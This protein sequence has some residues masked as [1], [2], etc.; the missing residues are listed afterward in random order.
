MAEIA[1][2]SQGSG[3]HSE[4][5]NLSDLEL[6]RLIG[7]NPRNNHAFKEFIARFEELIQLYIFRTCQELNYKSGLS[8][9]EDLTQDIYEQLLDNN[10]V[11]LKQITKN[12]RGYLIEM[13]SNTARNHRRKSFT[14]KRRPPGGI[15]PLDPDPPG[16]TIPERRK[17]NLIETIAGPDVSAIKDLMDE[18]KLCLDH[19]LQHTRKKERDRLIMTCYLFQDLDPGEIAALHRFD[20]TVKRLENLISA[21]MQA[22]RQCLQRKGFGK[23]SS[24]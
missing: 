4:L 5:K 20:L 18:V 21:I 19:I 13:A 8:K 12:V 24:P 1:F 11:K 7:E 16:W 3:N 14:L 10:C 22:L 9:I 23:R 2:F 17:R 6:V 15:E